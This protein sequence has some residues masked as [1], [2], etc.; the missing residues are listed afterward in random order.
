MGWNNFNAGPVDENG[1]L[2]AAVFLRDNLLPS[3][4]DTVVI[5]GGWNINGSQLII[6]AH[7]RPYPRVDLFPSA[8]D[9]HG[10][11]TLASQIHKMGLKLGVWM[12]RGMD[13]SAFVANAPIWNSTFTTRDAGVTTNNCAFAPQY[14]MGTN[15]PSP[16]AAAWY[17][18][19]AQLY[20]EQSIDFIKM[21]C[22]YAG[23]KGSNNGELAAF[24]AAF[25]AVAPR[26]V[27]SLSP[28]GDS[29]RENASWVAAGGGTRGTL[30]RV[31]TDFHDTEGDWALVNHFE[32]AANFSG[33]SGR[34]GT[35]FDLDMLPFSP[36][37]RPC[38]YAP[39][40]QRMLFSLYCITR[41]PLM[42]GTDMP[43][44]DAAALAL[45]TNPGALAVHGASA[46]NRNIS[47]ARANTSTTAGLY[48]WA[49]EP[50]DGSPGVY[51]A[52]FNLH[53]ADALLAVAV[54]QGAGAP[55]LCAVD[56][57]TGAKAGAAFLDTF[58]APVADH[59]GGLWRLA[60]C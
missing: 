25:S 17:R 15:A 58:A 12:N 55:P 16:A 2:A 20:V 10:F 56:V 24:S 9:G 14:F 30:Y 60:P 34:N 42:L 47:V 19:I 22:M 35:F 21:D 23:H 41:A 5:D 52:L 53:G 50:T 33:Y 36:A 26:V 38:R 32:V 59:T 28:G 27:I 54:P 40:T 11:R 18:S 29:S 6:D 43:M 4:Y 37:G 44:T 31:V 57:Y 45:V 8:A 51:V 48:A 7:G 39:A 1:I 13:A 3:G 46:N 49:A